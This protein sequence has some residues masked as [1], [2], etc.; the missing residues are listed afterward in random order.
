MNSGCDI[1]FTVANSN[2]V[3]AS[4]IVRGDVQRVKV[5]SLGLTDNC[6]HKFNTMSE[7]NIV[8]FPDNRSGRTTSS[9]VGELGHGCIDSLIV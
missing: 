8:L 5:G 2:S 9:C 3:E 4:H 7:G 6:G 1:G